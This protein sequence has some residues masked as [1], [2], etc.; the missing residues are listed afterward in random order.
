MLAKFDAIN[1]IL[2]KIKTLKKKDI[3]LNLIVIAILTAGVAIVFNDYNWYDKPIVKIEKVENS[4]SNDS[5]QSRSKEKYYSQVIIGIIMN[6]EHQ[7]EQVYLENQY[8][9]SGL[10]DDQYKPGNEVFVKID[11]EGHEK[12]TGSITGLKRDKY[13]AMLLA[14]F[15]F[16]LFFVTKR[17]G[18]FAVISLAINIAVLWYALHLNYNGHNILMI[19]NCLVLFFTFTSLLFIGGISRKTFIAVL[20]TLAS[21][22][23][24]MLLFKI[25][26]HDS[27]GV[28]YTYMEYIAGQNNLSELF[29]AQI[30]IGGLGAIMDVAI[31]E[32]SAINELVDKNSEISLKELLRSGREVGYDI[33]GTMINVMLF[34]YVCGTIPLIILKMKNDVKL[35]SIIIWQMPMEIYRF[36]I[37]SIGILL[38]IPISLFISII[39]FKK[40]RRPA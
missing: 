27:D 33:M 5:N 4:P 1:I 13:M 12:L 38:A 29:L 3:I 2:Q 20:S 36:L 11:S 26:I 19:S 17:K 8:S 39:L 40:F 9:S 34:T 37:G 14:L 18:F 24:T 31:T 16:F 32:A 21:L 7:G 15:I 25:M 10:L 23:F 35:H 22:F 28:D 30:L 6:G